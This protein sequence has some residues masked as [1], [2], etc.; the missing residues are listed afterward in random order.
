MKKKQLIRVLLAD[1]HPIVMMG[2]AM[3]LADFD[4]TVI[5]QATTPAMAIGKY[6]K[7]LPDVIVL[8]IRFGEKLTGFDTA[9]E[10]LQTFPHAKIVFLSQF[11]Q[12]RL[13]KESYRLGGSAFVT[14]NCDPELLATAISKV[15][16]GGIF[17]LPEIAERLANSSIRG[18]V[19][20]QSLLEPREIEIFILMANGSTNAEIAEELGF[21]TKTI[22][23]ASQTIKDKLGIH[24]TAEITKMAMKHGLIEL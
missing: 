21:S 3:A 4:M 23:N 1:D 13:I 2:F 15:H 11:D 6:T 16:K 9:K 20:P 22:S 14:K 18:D 12:D 8:D 17:F 7:L 10:I 5:G 19:S 24:R